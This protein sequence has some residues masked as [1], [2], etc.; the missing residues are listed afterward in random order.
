M[1]PERSPLYDACEHEPLV[2]DPWDPDRVHAAIDRIAHQALAA[3]RP[4]G[5]WPR[6]PGDDYG[7]RGDSSLW[8]G[9]A[10]TLWA[11][12]Q[13]GH[14][15]GEAGL[16][17]RWRACPDV[18]GSR[19]LMLGETG[20]ALVSWHLAADDAT[21]DRLHTLVA[22]TAHAPDHELFSGGPGTMLAALHLQE[23]T[24]DPRW[25]AL[26]R[27]SADALLD[28]FRLDPEYGCRL[29]IQYRRGRLLRSLGA[30]HGFCSN[31]RS[32][33]RGA[34]LL[35]AE[36]A[37]ELEAAAAAT[38]KAFAIRDG[39]LV[40]WPTAADPYWAERFPVRVQWCH[41]APGFLTSLARL[42]RDAELDLLFTGAGEL[43]WQAGPL[44]KGAGLCHGTAG[45]GCA[46]L[47]LHDRTGEQ[48]W[49]DRARAF[50]M[51]ALAQVEA[52]PP[53]HSLWTGSPGVALYLRMCLDG[54]FAGVPV[55]DL[56]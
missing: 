12:E 43:V 1:S 33:L 18:P 55:I 24:G 35:G 9:A 22:E 34:A 56:I 16:Y 40:N 39:A 28:E 47:A 44:R 7:Q 41:G 13:L 6:H 46:L 25:A 52:A 29:W 38:V 3:R 32:L 15:A 21:A 27:A 5:C 17:A 45:N 20:V 42:P 50:G 14:R 8:I 4:D 49:L 26:W 31:V 54:C 23:A 51:H 10:G 11:L 53:R 30:G 2:G 36:R 19:G 48:L 37:A